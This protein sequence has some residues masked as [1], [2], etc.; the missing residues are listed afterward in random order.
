[1]LPEHELVLVAIADDQMYLM[2]ERV[3]RAMGHQIKAVENRQALF[4]ALSSGHVSLMVIGEKFDGGAGLQIAADVHQG[5][6]TLPIV[7][8]A[9]HLEVASLVKALRSGVNDVISLPIA[10]G[11]IRRVIENSLAQ[12]K[13]NLERIREDSGQ[14]TITLQNRKDDLDALSRISQTIHAKLDIDEV[15]TAIVAAAVE[16]S[17]AEEGSLFIL[18]ESSNRLILRAA[19]N[20]DDAAARSLKIPVNDSIAGEVLRTGKPVLH[21]TGSPQKI[22]TGYLVQ[23]LIYVPLVVDGKVEGVLGVDNRR[24]MATLGNHQVKQLTLLGEMG[25][26]AL[27]NAKRFRGARDERQVIFDVLDELQD[28]VAFLNEQCQVSRINK[29]ARDILNLPTGNLAGMAL[30]DLVPDRDTIDALRHVL[31]R[32]DAGEIIRLPNDRVYQITVQSIQGEGKALTL[33]ERTD[34]VLVNKFKDDF[35]QSL[36]V[37]LHEPLGRALGYME[38]LGQSGQ[39]NTIQANF[40]R[41]VTQELTRLSHLFDN[42]MDLGR[43]ESGFYKT[44]E[45]V[46][47]DDI[48]SQTANARR[49][50]Y[51]EGKHNVQVVVPPD[52]LIIEANPAMLRILLS[53]LLDNALRFTPPGGRVAVRLSAENNKAILRVEDSGSGISQLD[54]PYIYDKFYHPTSLVTDGSGLGLAMV[55]SILTAM[56]G[57][58]WVDSAVGNGS[59]FTVILPLKY[60]GTR[61]PA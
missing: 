26:I 13:R 50:R 12:N 32:D 44:T 21:D 38:L 5:W 3:L 20:L 19:R 31:E 39:L 34:Q 40:A 43:I 56:N 59:T 36:S 4:L 7:L 27:E 1:M 48:V 17:G 28:G 29:A 25:G 9:A 42:L 47:L 22:A 33:S 41:Q 6:S 49:L 61:E 37:D 55:K 35:V 23:S 60:E 24:R 16:M 53:Q 2:L 14:E 30:T 46:R 8:F 54:I 10:A 58:I 51:I 11:E 45:L 52:P 18:D 57:K 15:L